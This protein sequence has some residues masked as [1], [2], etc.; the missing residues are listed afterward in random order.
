MEVKCETCGNWHN[1]KSSLYF[2]IQG[3]IFIGE[4]GGVVGNHFPISKDADGNYRSSGAYN[5]EDPIQFSQEDVRCAYFCLG[6]FQQIISNLITEKHNEAK[7]AYSKSLK[8][9]GY[10]E[11]YYE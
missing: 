6:C 5:P 11:E 3:N 4:H 10:A 7:E 1:T 9:L 8:A 2:K